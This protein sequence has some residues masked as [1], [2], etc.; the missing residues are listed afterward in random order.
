MAFRVGAFPVPNAKGGQKARDA[1]Q[2]ALDA[3]A[4]RAVID[5]SSGE[6]RGADLK[7]SRANTPRLRAS[8]LRKV[9][10]TETTA[11]DHW[12]SIVS[13]NKPDKE[14]PG[15]Q[16]PFEPKVG[17][18]TCDMDHVLELQVMGT[19]VEENIQ[20][21]DP[22]PNR[23]SGNR[24][25]TFLRK[26]AQV[27]Y[28]GI[29][30]DA[31]PDSV[32]LHF[33]K[34]VTDTDP[35]P[36][37]GC[38][39]AG[40]PAVSCC[41]VEQCA[42]ASLEERAKN[43]GSDSMET[44]GPEGTTP[45]KI[46]AGGATATI[47]ALPVG[48]TTDLLK[49]G[50]VNATAADLIPGVL[51]ETLHRTSKSGNTLR[52]KLDRVP[53]QGHKGATQ[54]PVNLVGQ[55]KRL[56]FAVDAESRRLTL[57][58][59]TT[60]LAFVYPFLSRGTVDLAY[61]P[62]FG[63]SGPGKL[64][65]SVPLLS[66]MTL[67]VALDP[68]SLRVR[69]EAPADKLKPPMPGFRF[70]RAELTALLLPDFK[71]EGVLAF[72]VG[73]QGRPVA[74]GELNISA[75]EGGLVLTGTLDAHLPRVERARGDIAYRNGQWSGGISIAS[76]QIGIPGIQRGQLDLGL[77]RDGVSVAGEVIA[78]IPGGS[79]VAFHVQRTK[80]GDCVYEG[81]TTL[82]VPG[83][84]PVDA[85]I[86]YDGRRFE[87]KAS[88]GVD[89]GPLSGKVHLHYVADGDKQT[90]NL[91]GEGKLAIKR[92]RVNG[93]FTG[94]VAGGVLTGDGQVWVQLTERLGG[95]VGITL[96]EQQRLRVKGGLAVPDP[97]R[98]FPRV[99]EG[100][101][102]K[103]FFNQKL[104]IPILGI[105]LGPL[106]AIGLIARISA[107]FGAR[108]HFGPGTLDKVQLE[109]AFNPLE[110]DVALTADGHAEL[111]IPAYAGV[112]LRLRGAL[113][114]SAAVASITG[115]LEATAELGVAG[116]ARSAVDL[117]YAKG[118]FTLEGLTRISA[119]PV[120]RLSLSANVIAEI[121]ALGLSSEWRKDWQLAGFEVGSG[122]EL[123]LEAKV[124]YSSKD[125]VRLPAPGEI[126]WI[127]PKS[128]DPA[129]IL[130]S[131]LK[132]AIR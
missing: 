61:D 128:I 123:G 11:A 40:T 99:P 77:T 103:E 116:S 96:D 121:G 93:T 52:G 131:L 46:T 73:P 17:G 107:G 44:A 14:N 27:A 31:T 64:T 6:A 25:A 60:Q 70:T 78:E 122:W 114:L 104:D 85:H 84:D 101:G 1:Y 9:G 49:S 117:H 15:V 21:L 24:I 4:L 20:V 120:L 92:G 109:I 87:G 106:G 41:Q 39:P 126:R 91:S 76:A 111:D 19:N 79:I 83:L 47:H 89:L 80:A 94:K 129:A 53:L 125:G 16:G 68:D 2:R 88:T 7:Q 48:S 119:S 72:E 54:I 105:T 74:T 5:I 45:Y 51:L 12:Q 43:G 112:Y 86:Q 34:V 55:P 29:G 108:Y 110:D 67:A 113:G 36:A 59:R 22:G 63:F 97:I 66:S 127:Y 65:P 33:T 56:D 23:Q 124:G 32:I 3:G 82:R 130:Q 30:S 35:E 10:W 71:P 62:E 90:S 98:L 42:I 102:Q 100:G 69:L 38:P 118:G 95:Y 132:R 115:G 81:D 26:L 50:P 13:G 18:Q 28:D 75:D 37:C 8:W 57:L 58:T